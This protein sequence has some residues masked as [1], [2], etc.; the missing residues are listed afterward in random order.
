MFV[1]PA[2]RTTLSSDGA[3]TNVPVQ[4]SRSF[5]FYRCEQVRQHA[6][7]ETWMILGPDLLGWKLTEARV[8]A[9]L[10]DE[11]S[12]QVCHEMQLALILGCHIRK[13]RLLHV[14]V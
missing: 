11:E 1:I 13:R 7:A 5:F 6:L 2:D 12:L 4:D 14:R 10:R 9:M 3:S 8:W